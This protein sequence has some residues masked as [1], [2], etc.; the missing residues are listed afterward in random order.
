MTLEIEDN[1]LRP[2]SIK[3]EEVTDEDWN[4]VLEEHRMLV[5]EFLSVN[6]HLSPQSKK[7]YVSGLRQFF[8]WVYKKLSNKPIYEIS[9][10]DFLRYMSYLDSH[11]MSSS[12]KKFK[13]STVSSLCNYIENVVADDDE[14]Y[15]YFRN[16]TKG[17]P[18][19]PKNQVYEKVKVTKEEYELM[20]NELLKQNDYMGA[21]W[22]A[23]AFNTGARRNEIRQFKTEIA[24]YEIPEGQN[25][26]L[27]H[28]IR[29]KG[30]SEDGK[31]LQYMFNKEAL[32][33]IKL[34]VDNRDYEHEYIFT[35][36]YNGEIN[37]ISESWANDF[38]TNTLSKMLKRR[39][40]PHIFKA[41]CIT[42]LL[43]KGIDIAQVSKYVAQHNDISTTIQH[44]DLRD[45][46]EERNKIFG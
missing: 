41:S 40:N 35:T 30:K 21:C 44:Y 31:P 46:E 1:L 24:N 16:F 23:V 15:K 33:Y 3:L 10:R 36:K 38:C 8:Y 26:I 22:L 14:K 45:G 2:R 12:G 39:I 4:N 20:I 32:E 34:W 13:R 27:S 11:K 28:T 17:L 18:P 42:Y 25:Y 29:G 37:I 6:T 7:Q 19:I 43:E 5:D 9:K